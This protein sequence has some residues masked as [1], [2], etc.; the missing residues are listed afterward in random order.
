[1]LDT[2]AQTTLNSLRWHWEKASAVNCDGESWMAI[3]AM[4][5]D[6]VLTAS[7][8]MELRTAMH[9]DYAARAMRSNAT[10]VRWA[11]FASL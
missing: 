7:S 6:V 2:D 9:N 8:A 5:P 4:A 11:S 1:M 10:A 3:P